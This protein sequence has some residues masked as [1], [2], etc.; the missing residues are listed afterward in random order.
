MSFHTSLGIFEHEDFLSETKYSIIFTPQE[1]W[2]LISHKKWWVILS[3]VST[4]NFI[5]LQR[6]EMITSV[7]PNLQ[8]VNLVL[9]RHLWYTLPIRKTYFQPSQGVKFQLNASHKPIFTGF[10]YDIE[11]GGENTVFERIFP[12][13]W[14][15]NLLLGISWQIAGQFAL[16]LLQ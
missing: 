13:F 16:V 11:S 8:N 10:W 12:P 2:K 14:A 4:K 9:D 7:D 3:L 5:L 6:D 15:S 1:M